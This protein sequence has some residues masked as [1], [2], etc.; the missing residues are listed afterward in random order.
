MLVEIVLL[1]LLG[2]QGQLLQVFLILHQEIVVLLLEHQLIVLV[3]WLKLLQVEVL[4][5]LLE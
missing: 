1:R 3:A 4:K 2:G 5:L